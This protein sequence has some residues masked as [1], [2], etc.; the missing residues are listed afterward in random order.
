[1]KLFLEKTNA[2]HISTMMSGVRGLEEKITVGSSS[3]MAVAING[4]QEAAG[5]T[6]RKKRRQVTSSIR[7]Q[8]RLSSR[9]TVQRQRASSGPVSR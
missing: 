2:D 1:M 9:H 3:T 4:N 8:A 6:S 5:R 7:P